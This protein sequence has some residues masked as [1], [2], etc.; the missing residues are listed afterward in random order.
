M[1]E[2]VGFKPWERRAVV[3]ASGLGVISMALV[4]GLASLA[5]GP[6]RL[7]LAWG[8]G[9]ALAWAALR[10][11][12]TGQNRGGAGGRLRR[13]LGWIAAWEIRFLAVTAML[14]VGCLILEELR[15][16]MTGAL[17]ESLADPEIEKAQVIEAFAEAC[18]Q[19]KTNAEPWIAMLGVCGVAAGLLSGLTDW[20]WLGALGARHGVSPRRVLS[21]G[22]SRRYWREAGRRE[23]ARSRRLLVGEASE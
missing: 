1:S 13:V 20:L 21:I 22:W 15:F 18:R 14:L 23:R 7:L 10:A 3:R 8:A 9:G 4:A 12:R 11:D 17:L 19:A 6:H 16:A 5:V 2:R